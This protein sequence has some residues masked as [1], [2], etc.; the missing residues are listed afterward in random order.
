MSASFDLGFG[1]H[2]ASLAALLGPETRK[3]CLSLGLFSCASATDTLR[4]ECW[5]REEDE[6]HAE[7]SEPDL[8]HELKKHFP[9][10]TAEIVP[11]CVMQQYCGQAP[12]THVPDF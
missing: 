10:H 5:S 3:A 2:N 8:I 6:R 11:L 9:L 12:T 7:G 1:C 4:S